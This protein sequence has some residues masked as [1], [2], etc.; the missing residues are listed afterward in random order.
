MISMADYYENSMNCSQVTYV[1]SKMD[2]FNENSV[3]NTVS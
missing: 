2:F 1:A 3:C